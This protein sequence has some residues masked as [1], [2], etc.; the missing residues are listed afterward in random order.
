MKDTEKMVSYG[1]EASP[2]SSTASIEVYSH[3]LFLGVSV[4]AEMRFKQCQ[5]HSLPF[6]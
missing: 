4:D 1:L 6:G 2:V 5:Y 3:L